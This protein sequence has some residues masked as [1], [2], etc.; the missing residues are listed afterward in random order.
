MF[1]RIG[2]VAVVGLV[3]AL[4]GCGSDDSAGGSTSSSA[5]VETTV[6]ISVDVL[7]SMLLEVGDV[8]AGWQAGP[9]ITDA[10][11]ADA[12][13]LPCPDT[14]INPTIADRLTPATGVQ[15]EPDDQSYR[16][17][18]QFIVNGSPDRLAADLQVF[19]DAMDACA[20]TTPTSTD[21]GSLTVSR[22]SIPELGDQGAGYLLVGVESPD[23]VWYVR[24]ASV[25][26]GGIAVQ[27][28]LTEILQSPQNEPAIT[29]AEFFALLEAAVAKVAAA[30]L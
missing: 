18:V 26:I 10:D 8:G 15:F 7:S 5:A 29:D 12:T 3:G 20:A 23:A 2:V 16:H 17:L 21:T 13:Q 19:H 24:Q 9:E 4:V 1:T 25:R 28:G 27:V 6:P 30:E 22:L 11:L 14:A